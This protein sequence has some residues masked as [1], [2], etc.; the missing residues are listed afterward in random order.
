MDAVLRKLARLTPGNL[1]GYF[2]ISAVVL[3]AMTSV[4]LL[5]GVATAALLLMFVGYPYVLVLGMPKGIVRPAITKW[6]R[7][8]F[9]VLLGVATFLAIAVPLMPEE[10]YS[11]PVPPNTLRQWFEVGFALVGN[12]AVFSPFFIG[13]AA[14]N[15]TRGALRQSAEL[16]S[17]P[18][19]LAL[20]FWPFGGIL[21]I[22]R[23]VREVLAAV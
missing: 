18:N 22:H 16:E 4:K 1:L 6:A 7:L 21:H 13:A 10:G 8:W 19:F 5:E 14:L 2:W 15:D 11:T 12:V 17:I 20:Y 23:R 9:V 3:A